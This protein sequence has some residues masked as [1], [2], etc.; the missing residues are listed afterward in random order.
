MRTGLIGRQF[1]VLLLS[2]A[3]LV[4]GSAGAFAS[5]AP[6]D[7]NA[8]MKAIGIAATV[9]QFDY[10]VSAYDQSQ[11]KVTC[12]D[13]L[14]CISCGACTAL[15]SL[16]Q[17]EAS[18]PVPDWTGRRVWSPIPLGASNSIRPALPPP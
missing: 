15:V 2:L 12:M 4:S 18:V 9:S 5:A 16:P 14:T 1:A 11:C 8:S 3:I 6:M 7:C 13:C 17:S 10:A